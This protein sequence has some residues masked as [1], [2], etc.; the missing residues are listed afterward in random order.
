MLVLLMAV[1]S[2]SVGA[3][4]I[5][6][7]G[8]G[9]QLSDE[10]TLF[11]TSENV[12]AMNYSSASA[13][14]WHA[15]RNQVKT[16]ICNDGFND[17]AIGSYTFCN[18]PKLTYMTVPGNRNY[19]FTVGEHAF[20]NSYN[21]PYIVTHADCSYVGE[22]AFKKCVRLE[23]VSIEEKCTTIG[24]H[25]FEGC[26][27]LVEGE[28]KECTYIGEDA[29]RDCEKLGA[30]KAPKCKTICARAFRN[31][32]LSSVH[33]GSAIQSIGDYAFDYGI[34]NNATL[35]IDRSTPPTLGNYVFDNVLCG[36]VLLLFPE[37]TSAAWNEYPWNTF[38]LPDYNMTPNVCVYGD[39]DY[40]NKILT[41]YYG[42]MNQN[43][44]GHD[45]WNSLGGIYS[46][47]TKVI[48]DPSMANAPLTSLKNMFS[49]FMKLKEIEGLEYLN[50]QNVTTME[51]MFNNCK[52]LETIDL[53]R[54]NTSNVTDM[55][56]L[57]SLCSKLR[58]V[59][60]TRWDM[61]KVTDVTGMFMLCS[62]LTTIYC[63]DDW[64]TNSKITGSYMTFMTCE[65]LVGGNGTPWDADHVDKSYARPDRPGQPGYFTARGL[66]VEQVPSDK[67]QGTKVIR[68]GMLLI[69]R[70][71]KTY[72]AQG[73]ECTK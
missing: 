56:T 33:L 55:S 3:S 70:N 2:T 73:I 63:D 50:T 37:G 51:G 17:F 46:V 39:M 1:M 41:L 18:M 28:L 4:E 10:G 53:S 44:Y 32:Q 67:G 62:E 48:I 14:P 57:F 47:T 36:Y 64:S 27:N 19:T 15:Y 9:W 34:K 65:K 42:D 35:Q 20:E 24:H 69:E 22:Y 54:L 16:I 72:N 13:A 29:F 6:A 8:N 49:S 7:S 23:S 11:I 58:S 59:D 40:T 43:Q 68:N 60:L 12:M 30:I 5:V 66:D 26:E 61:S 45:D 52:E 31:C 21:L 38:K 71:G 25:A